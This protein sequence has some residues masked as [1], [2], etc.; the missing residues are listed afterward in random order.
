MDRDKNNITQTLKKL[1]L[2]EHIIAALIVILI[3]SVSLIL[4]IAYRSY[5]TSKNQ[6]TETISHLEERVLTLQHENSKLISEKNNQDGHIVSLAL[7][8][9]SYKQQLDSLSGTKSSYEEQ[10][11]TL[12]ESVLN[13]KKLS[14]LDSELLKKYSRTY[15]LNEHYVPNSLSP[16]PSELVYPDRTLEIHTQTLPFLTRMMVAAKQEKQEL[17][18]TSAYRSFEKQNKLK[19]FYSGKV[20]KRIADSF[21][22]DNGLSEHQLGTTVDL[23][24]RSIGGPYDSFAQTSQYAWLTQ[25]A[26]NYGFVLSYPQNNIYFKFEPWHWRFIGVELATKL[27]NE[28]KYFNDLPQ[29]EIDTY[30]L[31]IFDN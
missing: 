6:L 23:T 5:I 24:T 30:L 10:L 12:S 8:A 9:T 3:I 11:K 16:I 1:G 28:N 29:R 4:I 15:F 17:F 7:L 18:V 19:S 31:P 2:H 20:G 21:S 13:Y 26:H 27:H 25:N 22:A 14:T